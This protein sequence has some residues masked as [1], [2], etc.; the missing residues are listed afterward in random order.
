MGMNVQSF[1]SFMCVSCLIVGC[2]GIHDS[3]TDSHRQVFQQLND[4]N[5]KEV[6][7]DSC[8]EDWSGCWTLDGLKAKVTN[9]DKGMDFKA[10]PTRR[11]NASHAV[12]WT[13]ESFAG[14]IRIDYEYTKLEDVVEA[15]TILYIQ[16]TGSGAEGYDKDISKWADKREVASM[17]IYFNH[18]NLYHISYAAFKIDNTDPDKDYIRARRYTPESSTGLA[19]TDLKPDYFK[20]GLFKKGV[21]HKI[22]VIKKGDDLF[23]YIRNTEKEQLCHWKTDAFPPILEGRI[24]LRHMWTRRACYRNF[25]ISQLN[26]R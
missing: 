25:R 3:T 21:P 6:F 14:N 1:V 11:E 17:A 4:A 26:D 15:V 20:T 24:G 18:M 5:W 23:M 10:G 7:F 8:T 16:S 12:M 2:T 13:K 9:S 22:T 19:N